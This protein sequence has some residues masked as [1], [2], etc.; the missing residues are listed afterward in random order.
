MRDLLSWQDVWNIVEYC[1]RVCHQCASEQGGGLPRLPLGYA[2]VT[3]RVAYVGYEIHELH[4]FLLAV[5]T[6]YVFSMC[7]GLHKFRRHCAGLR[8][9]SAPL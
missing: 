9:Y 2:V 5:T 6:R 3:E 8:I 7:Y 4:E 1:Q